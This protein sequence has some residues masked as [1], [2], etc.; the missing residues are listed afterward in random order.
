LLITSEG[1]EELRAQGYAVHSGDLGE[2][3]TTAG[4]DR[5]QIHLGHRFRVGQSII[6]I[7]K[8]RVPCATLDRFN[9][10]VQP[11]IQNSLYD[12]QVKA[13]DS[14]SARWGL[15]GFYA[16]ILKAGLVRA[17]DSICLL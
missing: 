4:L 13:G 12:R 3:F 15:G 14:S 7:T 8:M 10:P 17:G 5:H 1:L 9:D 6:E 2:N 11:K 16:R